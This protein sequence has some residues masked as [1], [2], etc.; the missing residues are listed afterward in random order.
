MLKIFAGIFIFIFCFIIA[1]FIIFFVRSTNTIR[2]FDNDRSVSE[3]VFL[4]INGSKNGMI[5]RGKNID[6]PVLLFISGGPGVP[7]YWMNEYY[8]NDIEN[9]YTVCWWDYYGE[10]LSYSS[11]IKPEEITMDRLE[12]DAAEITEYLKKRFSK[13]K[14][15]LMAHSAG[16]KLGL[17]LA[18]KRD[19]LYYCYYSMGQIV[20]NGNDR[21]MYGYNFMKDIFN[22]NNDK[23]SLDYMNSLV[24]IDEEKNA[25]PKDPKSIASSWENVLLSAGCATTRNM[26]S[27]AKEI[28]YPQMMSHCYTFSEKINYWRG[29]LLCVKSPYMDEKI[30]LYNEKDAKIP[31]YFI[32][33][34]YDYTCPT[35]LVQKLYQNINAPKKEIFILN[36]SAHSPLWEQNEEVLAIMR[37]YI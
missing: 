28:F 35:P 26:R 7:E 2:Q 21:Y 24:T 9:Y 36:D 17:R 3:K 29:K 6:N 30:P 18:Q 5:I 14:V 25:V 22:Q 1:V 16:T 34:Y 27:D 15:Y 33:G 11:S 32:N 12:N 10:G 20:D 23:K 4:D 31:I 8:N 19:D 37:K 13:E